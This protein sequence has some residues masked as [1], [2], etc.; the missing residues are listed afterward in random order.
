VK[1]GFLWVGRTREPEFSAAIDRYRKRIERHAEVV[2]E[3]APEAGRRAGRRPEDIA[4]AEGRDLQRMLWKR[5]QHLGLDPAGRAV[6]SPGM[7]RA[8]EQALNAGGG[9][10]QFV[11][12]GAAGLDPAVR[13][14]MDHLVSLTPLTLT[15][16]MARLLLLEQVY[17]AFTILRGEPYH[18]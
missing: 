3:V 4:R 12:G 15:H 14:K 16:E 5:G 8:L 18:K 1:L 9:H 17:R 13:G 11:L 2:V 10:V 6:D 7:A